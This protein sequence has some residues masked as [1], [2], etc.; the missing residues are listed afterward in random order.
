MSAGVYA[1]L[2]D[3][4]AVAE[5]AVGVEAVLGVAGPADWPSGSG[6]KR[7]AGSVAYLAYPG[8]SSTLA[9][10]D[11]GWLASAGCERPVPELGL[12]AAAAAAA[13]AAV[14]VAAVERA[15]VP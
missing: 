4:A 10:P 3:Q 1:G 8:D 13:H 5:A 6:E 14:A 2:A 15:A 9:V 11:C 12:V 7:R